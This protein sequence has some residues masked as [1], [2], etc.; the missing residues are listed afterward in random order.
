MALSTAGAASPR[1]RT[2][3]R[4]VAGDPP[5]L[6]LLGPRPVLAGVAGAACIAFSAVLVRLAAVEPATAAVFRCLYALPVLGLL[7]RSEDRRLGPRPRRARLVAAGAGVFFALDLVIW[8]HAIAAV[9]AGLGTVLGNLQV[10]VVGIVAWVLLGERLSRRLLLA[11]PLVL[12]G[13]TL[14]SGALGGAT[15]G[16]HPALGVVLGVATSVAYAGFLLVL[17][18]SGGDLR[19]P[20]GPLFD[21]TAVTVVVAAALGLVSGGVNLVPSWPAHGWLLLLALSSQVVGWLLI[22]VSLPRLPAAV[23]SVLL[24]LQP[25]ASVGLGALLLGES[26]STG[27]LVGV[28]LILF[29]VVAATA[30]RGAQADARATR[31][32]ASPATTPP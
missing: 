15:Y 8:H 28:G 9:G 10:V 31:M 22:S 32:A 3:T 7:M 24:L 29:G 30:G 27:Q 11:I 16:E 1:G 19:R 23:T 13:V 21:A 5:L 25:V 4:R 14:I 20:A 2:E 17:R 18:Q 12:A 26:P 6:A